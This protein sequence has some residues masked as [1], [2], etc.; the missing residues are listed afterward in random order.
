MRCH[1]IVHFV[2]SSSVVLEIVDVSHEDYYE[3]IHAD[4][5][6]VSGGTSRR[7][8]LWCNIIDRAWAI[9]N[10]ISLTYD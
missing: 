4:W 2:I 10:T 7:S 1:I 8:I 5:C 6:L 9:L 3:I